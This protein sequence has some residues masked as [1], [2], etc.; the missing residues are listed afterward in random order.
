[1]MKGKLVTV[2]GGSG[3]IGRHLVQRLA[4]AGARVRAAVRHPEEADFL[5]PMGN[6]GQVVPV[7]ASV[8]HEGSVRAAL[9]GADA[10]VNL[11]GILYQRGRRSFDAIH[12]RG[13]ETVARAAREAGVERLVHMS[14][15]G[16]DPESASKY[17]RSKAAGEDAVRRAFPEA[18]VLRP[19]VVFGPQDG[20]F[21]LFAS[22]ARVSP[23]LPVFGCPPPRFRDGRLDVYGE[24]GVKFQPV[25]V[26]D[27]AD[28]MMV[29]L[30]D[31]HCAG[32]TY[33]LG[34]PAVY[35]FKEIM[36]LVQRETRRKRLLLPIPYWL[37]TIEAAFLQLLPKPL[38][39]VDQVRLLKHDNVLTGKHP[40]LKELGIKPVGAEAILPTYLDRYR[41]GGRFNR[42]R[43]A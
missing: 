26:G 1:M 40:G 10:A 27:V 13:A 43:T 16:A 3:F 36:D 6:V 19:S 34:G 9:D 15:L 35:S 18:S 32:K 24:G 30:T 38:L 28:A 42:T 20:F 41:P 11:V 39:T 21:N 5:K 12:R 33:E 23:V 22:L 8:S 2:F 4:T 29:C 37:G 25:Y 14:A 17:A 31:P 7:R